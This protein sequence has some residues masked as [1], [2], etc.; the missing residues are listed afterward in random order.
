MGKQ[1]ELVHIQPGKPQQNGQVES[2]NGKL[3]DE[4][5][6]VSWFENLWDARRKIAAWQKEYNEERPHSSLGYQ[7]PAAYA[8]RLLASSGV[9]RSAEPDEAILSQVTNVV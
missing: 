6:N 2:F 8:R 4:C 5:S 7:T 1:I 9:A 3:R